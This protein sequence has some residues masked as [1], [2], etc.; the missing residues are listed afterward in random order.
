MDEK[1]FSTIIIKNINWKISNIYSTYSFLSVFPKNIFNHLKTNHPINGVNCA[2]NSATESM[3][4]I[5]ICTKKGK[6]FSRASTENWLTE[7]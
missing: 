6:E 2:I 5:R 1:I 4:C 3:W 7:H